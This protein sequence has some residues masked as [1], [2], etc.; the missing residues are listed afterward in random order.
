MNRKSPHARP[1]IRYDEQ[2]RALREVLTYAR[3]GTRL[4]ATQQRHWDDHAAAWV[5]DETATANWA[6]R[7]GRVAPLL[8]EI[9]SGIGEA[10]VALATAHAD[11]N[12]LA[13]EV[14]KPG[15][16]DTLGR[17]AAAGVT[18]LRVCTVD[19]VWAFEH[20]LGPG[21]IG[22][23]LTFFPDPWHKK[24][25]H[26]RRLIGADFVALAASRLAEGALWRLATDAQEYADQILEVL[27]AEP[28]LTGGIVDRWE[29]RPLTKFER[30]GLRE[31]RTISDFTYRRLPD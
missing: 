12:V 4:T 17:A 29:G 9:G 8:V 16:A 26:K 10:A 1:E 2:G 14:W 27:D 30:R 18:N 22:E 5:I 24:R 31:G 3:R 20:L 11:A 23:L 25:H 19:A 28:T 6:D 15:V 13:F 21:S 7:F